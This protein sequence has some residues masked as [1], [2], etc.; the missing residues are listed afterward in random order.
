MNI[1]RLLVVV[2]A[3]LALTALCASAASA[4][5]ETVEITGEFLG[6]PQQDSLEIYNTGTVTL[7]AQLNGASWNQLDGGQMSVQMG[8]GR[9]FKIQNMWTPTEVP[10]EYRWIWF[11]P[12]DVTRLWIDGP[13]VAVIWREFGPFQQNPGGGIWMSAPVTQISVDVE[14][15]M[16]TENVWQWKLTAEP[17]WA[18]DQWPWWNRARTTLFTNCPGNLVWQGTAPVAILYAKLPVSWVLDPMAD[19]DWYVDHPGGW[20]QI[21]ATQGPAC[22]KILYLPIVNK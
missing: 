11:L 18:A 3:V 8:D 10:G 21:G 7:T 22:K 15:L 12:A 5:G 13:Q 1:K 9:Q 4:Q 16:H 20:A 2:L 6:T 14:L 17:K 19:I